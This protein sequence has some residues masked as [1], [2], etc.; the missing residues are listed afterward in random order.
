MPVPRP[1]RHS[2]APV[3]NSKRSPTKPSCPSSTSSSPGPETPV[4]A[5]LASTTSVI[6]RPKTS[7]T[8]IERRYRKNLNARIQSL[9]SAVPALRVLEEK[10]A[11]GTAG[12]GDAV[13]DRG[14]VDGVKVARKVSK[15]NV[16]GKAVEYI[17]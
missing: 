13:D 4:M 3:R 2:K 1:P 17:R 14:Y 16:L 8:T 10:G 6:G 12:W 11:K 7:H 5:T 9:K 15:A